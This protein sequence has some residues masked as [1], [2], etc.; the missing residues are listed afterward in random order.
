MDVCFST[1]TGDQ[2]VEI[3]RCSRCGIYGPVIAA[4][5]PK[6]GKMVEEKVCADQAACKQ[7]RA[8]AT[9]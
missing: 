5:V 7:R 1:V 4:L 9:P 3:G 2:H 6:S 8:I